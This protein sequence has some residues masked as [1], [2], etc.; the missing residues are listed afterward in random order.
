MSESNHT[1]SISFRLGLEEFAELEATARLENKSVSEIARGCVRERLSGNTF[2]EIA[3]QEMRK[4]LITIEEKVHNKMIEI[5][6]KIRVDIDVSKVMLRS[7]AQAQPPQ[8]K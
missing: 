5:G 4:G 7:Q 6:S 3:R 8:K 1:K 2:V